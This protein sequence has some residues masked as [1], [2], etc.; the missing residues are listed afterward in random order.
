MSLHEG[1]TEMR[2]LRIAAA[3]AVLALA[4][5]VAGCGGG[6]DEASDDP[7]TV[8][9]DTFTDT[10][11]DETTTDDETTDETDTGT[12][13]DFDFASEECQELVGASAALS[14]A[15]ASIGSG[16][17]LSDESEAFQAFVDEVPEEIRDDVQVLADAFAEYADV[18]EGIDLQAG[19]TPTQAQALELSQAL[20]SIDQAEVT[21][22]SERLSAWSQENCTG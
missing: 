2:W 21:A 15:F 7:E 11:T 1:G 4:L 20:S 3:L 5:A 9:T 12:S 10:T 14:Q 13:T 18:L 17:D 6:D 22:A 8:I 16:D 19:E